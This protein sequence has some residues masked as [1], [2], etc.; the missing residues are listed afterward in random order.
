MLVSVVL[1]YHNRS[2]TLTAAAASVL[3]QTHRDLELLLVD[4][5]STDG[6]GTV[7][8]TLAAA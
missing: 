8:D 6:S 3:R 4:D 7:L 5:C 1:P 2:D